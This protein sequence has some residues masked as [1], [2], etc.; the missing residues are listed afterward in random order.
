MPKCQNRT[1]LATLEQEIILVDC[2]TRL[3]SEAQINGIVIDSG[4]TNIRPNLVDWQ[5]EITNVTLGTNTIVEAIVPIT[6]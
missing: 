4:Q 1:N 5:R 6:P 3:S 2:W